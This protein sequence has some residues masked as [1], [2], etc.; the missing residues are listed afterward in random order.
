MGSP[1]AVTAWSTAGAA[2]IGATSAGLNY[3]E[4]RKNRKMS[5][6]NADTQTRQANLLFDEEVRKNKAFEANQAEQLAD[7][8]KNNKKSADAKQRRKG[9]GGKSR[10]DT[11][12]TGSSGVTDEGSGSGK[13]RLLGV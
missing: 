1:Q 4:A 10:A 11:I 12:L 9:K 2:V 8:R 6:S 7:N 13:R 5:S 3:R